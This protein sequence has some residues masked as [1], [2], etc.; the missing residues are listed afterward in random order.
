MQAGEIF[1]RSLD[2]DQTLYN[3]ARLCVES[4]ADLC[5]FDLIDERSERLY[6]TA[7]AHHDPA[8]ESMVKKAESL[9]YNAEF[10]LHPVLQ[11]ANTGE[12]FFIERLDEE[13]IRR[14]AASREHA[15]YMLDLG[16]RSKIV[17]P[18]GAGDQIFGALTFV[19][20]GGGKHF[21]RSD[22]DLAAELGRRAGIAVAN[23]KQFQR[24]Q[25]VAATL[26]R[27]FLNETLPTLPNFRV[28]AVYHAAITDAELGGDWYDAYEV[29]GGKFVLTI[30]DVAGKGV[31]AARTMVQ[32]RQ[33]IRIA[34]IVSQDPGAVLALVNKAL[35]LERTEKMATCFV[36]FIDPQ[37]MQATYASAGHV[38][39]FVR[40]RDGRI[41]PLEDPEPPLGYSPNV[42]FTAHALELEAGSFLVTYTDG[43]TEISKDAVRGEAALKEVLASDAIKFVANPARFMERAT[44]GMKRRDDVAI[45]V[46]GF[47]KNE[48]IWRLDAGDPRAAYAVKDDFADAIQRFA[49]DAGLQNCCVI[50]A[51]L[52]GNSVR[53]APGP[54]SIALVAK[55]DA[56]ILHVI[57]DGPGFEFDPKLPFDI[58]SESGR[59]LYLVS[60]LANS[61][62]VRPP[63]GCGSH[64][65]VELPV[66]QRSPA[67][68]PIL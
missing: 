4:F 30:G 10:R 23:A 16:Y 24:E 40:H 34:S 27:A 52:I 60:M 55:G 66:R 13:G 21:D 44:Y 22:V 38:P 62:A 63:P 5:L 25:Y 57:D 7:A 48:A 14:H 58:W 39:P 46:A 15:Q 42:R 53:H 9:L 33:A 1:H 18:V 56:L 3:V 19:L 64:I 12:I 68:Q 54:L 26:Q 6:V 35:L 20:T 65:A 31:E 36:A 28:T 59:G 41:V 29:E 50:F 43:V 49:G 17:V 67:E 2:I 45:M 61:V 47:G 51:E 32:L 8:L 37:T 11:V